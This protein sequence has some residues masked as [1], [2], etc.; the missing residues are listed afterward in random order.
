[1]PTYLSS[2]NAALRQLLE[3]DPQVY[4]WG[5]DLLDP[6]GGAFKVTRGLQA[7][8]P[9]RVRT[10]P[11]SEATIVGLGAGMALRGFKPI[12]EIMFGDFITLAADQ[13]IN[14]ASKF[15]PMYAGKASAG[16]VVR[17][18]MGGGRGYG[19]THSQTL[20]KIFFGIPNL[21]IVSPSMFHDPGE[22][23]TQA[24]MEDDQPVLFIEHKLLYGSTLIPADSL[25]ETEGYPTA[26][27]RNFDSQTPDVTVIAYGGGSRLIAPLLESLAMEEIWI[28][29]IFPGAVQPLDMAPILASVTRTGRAVVVEEGTLDFGWGAEIAAQLSEKLHGQLHRPVR[30]VAAKNTIIPAARPLEADVLPSIA[31]VEATIVEVLE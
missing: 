15:G 9:E 4:I 31:A 7:D 24:V 27:V 10:T 16:L 2:L 5:E 19:P 17:T 25:I 18:P 6:Y 22:L 12:V 11:I 1:M 3:T 23:L 21:R 28:E 26:V 29:C 20:E 13:L 14:Y 8:F 30:R